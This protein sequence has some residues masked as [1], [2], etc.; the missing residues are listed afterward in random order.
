MTAQCQHCWEWKRKSSLNG[1]CWLSGEGVYTMQEDG[2]ASYRPRVIVVESGTLT[3][4]NAL[5]FA[6]QGPCFTAQSSGEHRETGSGDAVRDSRDCGD[7]PLRGK[8]DSEE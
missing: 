1:I 4:A 2:C 3:G 5:G 8:C 6:A 7:R